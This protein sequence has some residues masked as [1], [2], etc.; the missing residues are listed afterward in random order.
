MHTEH[1]YL[2]IMSLWSVVQNNYVVIYVL[3]R[4]H[5]SP[6][7]G[8]SPRQSIY[9]CVVK[10]IVPSYKS[11][12]KLPVSRLLLRLFCNLK[13]ST[14]HQTRLITEH[15]KSWVLLD[16]FRVNS[17]LLEWESF[18]HSCVI[19]CSTIETRPAHS[20]I[21][22][23]HDRVYTIIYCTYL[24]ASYNTA[25]SLRVL[26]GTTSHVL[27]YTLQQWK[28]IM[29]WIRTRESRTAVLR[30]IAK[31]NLCAFRYGSYSVDKL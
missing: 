18:N 25:E 20:V 14:T 24:H 5:S 22:T 21:A 29:N 10:F 28:Y 1:E 9:E 12:E 3:S 16:A 27:I 31:L 6:T 26:H 8:V 15:R 23:N 19:L 4:L 13:V 2:S 30:L 11:I 7:Q 17:F